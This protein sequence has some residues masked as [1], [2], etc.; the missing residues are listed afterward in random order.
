[1]PDRADREALDDA[2]ADWPGVDVRHG[3]RGIRP[4]YAPHRTT[5]A[6]STPLD[7]AAAARLLAALEHRGRRRTRPLDPRTADLLR[8]GAESR[9]A[10]RYVVGDRL[11]RNRLSAA[12]TLGMVRAGLTPDEALSAMLDQRNAG[13]AWVRKRGE[14]A[15]RRQWH[16]HEWPRAVE[17][18][19]RADL[20]S[21]SVRAA[22]RPR[23]AAPGRDA[24]PRSGG[25]RG[26]CAR[27]P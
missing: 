9:H 10:A 23:S 4:P 25:R 7:H 26:T 3:S 24:R 5:G 18:V 22:A 6:R 16:R 20:L 8:H 11:D 15:A 17:A 12:V 19:D 21:R 14:V 1:V 27:Q 2:A 13:G